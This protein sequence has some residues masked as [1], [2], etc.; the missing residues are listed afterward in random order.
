MNLADF[1][2]MRKPGRAIFGMA[3]MLLPYDAS[4]RIATDAYSECLLRTVAA[5][6]TPAVNMDTGYVNLLAPDERAQVLILAHDVLGSAP[7]VAGAYIEGEG[8]DPAE[9]YRREATR[10]AEHGGTPILF[11]TSR[12]HGQSATKIAQVYSRAVAGLP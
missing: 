9:L 6:L 12:L 4:G 2:T 3:A 8:G 10:I 5:G 7:F 11:Q 1:D